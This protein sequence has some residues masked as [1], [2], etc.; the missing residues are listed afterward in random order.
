MHMPA[1]AMP[2][3]ARCGYIGPIGRYPIAVVR[4]FYGTVRRSLWPPPASSFRCGHYEQQT[5]PVNA[6]GI[7]K[8]QSNF[9]AGDMH[10]FATLELRICKTTQGSLVSSKP[11]NVPCTYHKI[12]PANSA[13]LEAL[14]TCTTPHF[15]LCLERCRCWAKRCCA[16]V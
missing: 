11:C 6:N 15:F 1:A 14:L 2:P 8:Q 10:P 12:F 4:A 3:C 7:G 9:F 16:T 5:Y 13:P